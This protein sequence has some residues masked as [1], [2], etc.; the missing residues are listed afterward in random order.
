MYI[1]FVT[2][3]IKKQPKSYIDLGCF[4]IIERFLINLMGALLVRPTD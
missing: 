4:L 3:E 1:R 2:K